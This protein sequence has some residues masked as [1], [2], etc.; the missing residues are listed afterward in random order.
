V[1]AKFAQAATEPD[2]VT[3]IE[4]TVSAASDTVTAT[5]T[6]RTPRRTPKPAKPSA[7]AAAIVRRQPDVSGAGL[8][9]KLGVSDR[10]G[11]RILAT[12]N[13]EGTA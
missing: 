7:K 11:R 13:A 8:G 10:Q 3:V 4:T 1:V 2:P 6:E 9:R 12:V 5:A